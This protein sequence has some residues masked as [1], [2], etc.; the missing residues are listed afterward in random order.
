M[1]AEAAIA[2]FQSTWLQ[3]AIDSNSIQHFCGPFTVVFTVSE[4]YGACGWTHPQ[5]IQRVEPALPVPVHEALRRRCM[6]KHVSSR[7]RR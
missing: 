7:H 4:R 6:C 1:K 3:P 2:K 5:A